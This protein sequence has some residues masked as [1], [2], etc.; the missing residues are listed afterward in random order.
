MNNEIKLR[1]LFLGP[2]SL[3]DYTTER[4]VNIF[5]IRSVEAYYKDN[6]RTH[7]TAGNGTKYI[8]DINISDLLAILEGTSYTLKESNK[9][10]ENSNFY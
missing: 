10:T 5:Q 6:S 2:V 3:L 1:G 9:E 8:A 4:W 7:I